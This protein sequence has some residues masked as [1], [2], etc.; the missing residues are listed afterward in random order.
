MVSSEQYV[1]LVSPVHKVKDQ[2]QA[3]EQQLIT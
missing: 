2:G 1:L 3:Q